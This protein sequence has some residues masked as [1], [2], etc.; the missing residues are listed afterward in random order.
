M[1]EIA[2]GEESGAEEQNAAESGVYND[3]MASMHRLRESEKKN[4]SKE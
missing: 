3:Y 2:T 4:E 1:V